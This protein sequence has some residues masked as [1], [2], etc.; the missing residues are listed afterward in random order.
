MLENIQRISSDKDCQICFGYP[1]SA[2]SI[3]DGGSFGKFGLLVSC[4]SHNHCSMCDIST[5]IAIRNVLQLLLPNRVL[6]LEED[7]VFNLRSKDNLAC[8][9]GG[10]H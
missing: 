1:F 7:N 8:D 6:Q 9:G 10:T 3:N 2:G 5:H 4:F